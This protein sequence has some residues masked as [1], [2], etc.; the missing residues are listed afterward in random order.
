MGMTLTN[1]ILADYDPPRVRAGGLRIDGGFIEEVGEHVKASESDEIVDCGGAVVLPGLV[2]GH[3][4]LYSALAAGMPAPP[5]PPTNFHEILKYVWWRLDRAL[6]AESIEASAAIGALE[7]LRHGTTTLIDHHASP[8]TIEGSLDLI[9]AG[10]ARVGLRGVLCYESTDRNGPEGARAGLEENRRY[11]RRCADRESGQ[12]AALVGA[13]A[14]FTLG[15]ETLESLVDLARSTDLGIHIHLAE[16]PCDDELSRRDHGAGA[17]ERLERYGAVTSDAVLA[18]CIHLDAGA[19][20]RIADVGATIAHNPRSNMNNGVGYSRV[21]SID[22]AVMLGTDGIGADM[23]TESRMAA[24]KSHD[25]GAALGPDRV[26]QML[27]VSARR[28]SRSL[29]VT[30]G[31]L[32]PGA[33]GDVVITRYVPATPLAGDNLAAHWVFALDASYVHHVVVAGRWCLRDGVVQNVSEDEERTRAV[34]A[35]ESMWKRMAEL[36]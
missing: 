29:G 13:H 17:L 28:A 18:H 19:L 33:V 12:F 8:N 5:K 9:E 10:I 3:T 24:F 30:L 34:H 11:A 22:A 4:H 15:D 27:G 1:A 36:S 16:D 23:F 6:D 26:L 2:N 14:A 20:S 25:A 35:A 31:R 7:A 21:S 32:E